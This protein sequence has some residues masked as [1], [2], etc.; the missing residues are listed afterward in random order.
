MNKISYLFIQTWKTYQLEE[1]VK[2]MQKEAR[3]EL[4]KS[5]LFIFLV[6][7]ALFWFIQ[8]FIHSY[9]KNVH[10]KNL[11]IQ[12]KSK[13]IHSKDS[14]IQKRKWPVT[15]FTAPNIFQSSDYGLENVSES[16]QDGAPASLAW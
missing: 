1:S 12:E 5:F 7:N 15:T 6:N 3:S 14:F 4:K 16:F 9:K 10:S 8:E 13:I 2:N 11:F